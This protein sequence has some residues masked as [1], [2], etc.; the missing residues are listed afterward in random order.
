[1]RDDTAN[2]LAF[3]VL[4]ALID[5]AARRSTCLVGEPEVREGSSKEAL[6]REREGDAAD[7]ARDLA[8]PPLFGGVSGGARATGRIKH[9]IAWIGGHEKTA[10]N[11]R[12]R[13]LNDIRLIS[14][15]AGHHVRP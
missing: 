7:I 2:L 9:E 8:A 6:P 11:N 1:M 14:H 15:K 12:I 13:G 10:L 5:E 4:L 3:F